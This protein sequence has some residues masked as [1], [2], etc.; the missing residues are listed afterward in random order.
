M[1]R[2]YVTHDE[3]RRK[4]QVRKAGFVHYNYLHGICREYLPQDAATKL[5]QPERLT[6]FFHR[7][8]YYFIE[9]ITTNH[10]PLTTNHQPLTTNHQPLTTILL[11]SGTHAFSYVI[12]HHI[13]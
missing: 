2:E 9:Y 11:V 10:Q 5:S 7:T 3:N 8:L 1:E 13:F 12:W 6:L 4:T